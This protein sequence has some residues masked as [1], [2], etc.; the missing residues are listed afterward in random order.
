MTSACVVPTVWASI[1]EQNSEQL[2]QDT[3]RI[4]DS[5]D[6]IETWLL[7]VPDVQSCG[8]RSECS[9]QIRTVKKNLK[10]CLRDLKEIEKCY[11]KGHNPEEPCRIP[12]VPAFFD[13]PIRYT[14]FEYMENLEQVTKRYL[15]RGQQLYDTLKK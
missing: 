13:D 9:A 1:V 6:L 12:C 5:I 3:P 15:E 8:W 11:K 14:Y 4:A 10:C 7:L 2:D